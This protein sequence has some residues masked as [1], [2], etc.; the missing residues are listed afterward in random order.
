MDPQVVPCALCS[1]TLHEL[2]CL[3]GICA[4]TPVALLHLHDVSTAA[5]PCVCPCSIRRILLVA[6]AATPA[7]VHAGNL[8]L[9]QG[10]LGSC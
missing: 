10:K 2:L 1:L 6:K 8:P 9:C 4:V 3:T 7:P 5:M